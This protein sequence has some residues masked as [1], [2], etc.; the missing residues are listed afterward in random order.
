MR[1]TLAEVLG[2]DGYHMYTPEWLRNRVLWHLNEEQCIGRVLLAVDS[3]GTII[4]HVIARVEDASTASPVGLVSTIY[5]C[6]DFRRCGVARALLEASEAWL[7]EQ[8][9]STLATDTSETNQPLLEL[10]RQRGYAV[11]FHSTEKRMVRLS[12][13]LK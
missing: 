11:T 1:A 8:K 10:F 13:H 3:K 12:R 5:V 4:G 2:E 7:I 9:V 6:P